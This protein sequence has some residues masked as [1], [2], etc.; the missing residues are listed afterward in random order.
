YDTFKYTVRD[1]HGAE[2][3]KEVKVKITG[4]NDAPE[5]KDVNLTAQGITNPS[6]DDTPNLIGWHIDRTSINFNGTATVELA[7]N[8][9]SSGVR[10]KGENLQDWDHF[11]HVRLQGTVG[12][13]YTAW[14]PTLT[15]DPFVAEKGTTIE[16]DL[17]GYKYSKVWTGEKTH[18][19]TNIEIFITNT[20]TGEVK[21]ISQIDRMGHFSYKIP[22]T[23]E[24][25]ISFRA[26]GIDRSGD[27]KIDVD[28]YIDNVSVDTGIVG[29]HHDYTFDKSQFLAGASDVEGDKLDVTSVSKSALG[30]KVWIG[31]DGKIHYDAT[32]LK[33]LDTGKIYEDSFKYTVSDGHGGTT[34][35]TAKIKVYGDGKIAEDKPEPEPRAANDNP[36]NDL[37]SLFDD[38]GGRHHGPTEDNGA[39]QADNGNHHPALFDDNNTAHLMIA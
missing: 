24:Y 11:A 4:Q 10:F 15:S 28:L 17:S 22:D 7:E 12:K 38:N 18:D 19:E 30:A 27:G 23:G 35:A 1:N 34:E 29:T 6:F 9:Y 31:T 13:Y 32:G 25:K 37:L 14:G 36:L 16:M 21:E 39:R 2:V 3:T 8:R 33:D 5:V 20:L 26:D